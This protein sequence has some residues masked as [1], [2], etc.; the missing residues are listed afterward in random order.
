MK[1]KNGAG[2][3]RKLR[4]HSRMAGVVLLALFGIGLFAGCST[5]P[6]PAKRLVNHLSTK[7]NEAMIR[8]KVEKDKFP[9]AKE[10]GLDQD[11]SSK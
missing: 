3:A 11:S 1:S 2:S 8:S 4:T 9:T 10:V 5:M 7:T 6:N